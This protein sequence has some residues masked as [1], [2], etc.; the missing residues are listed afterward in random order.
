MFYFYSFSI[1][2]NISFTYIIISF[3]YIQ[4]LNIS[5]RYIKWEF[6][7][8]YVFFENSQ[9]IVI[10]T[11]SQ[12]TRLQSVSQTSW[13]KTSVLKDKRLR[14]HLPDHSRGGGEVPGCLQTSPLQGGAG[15][16][17][18]GHHLHRPCVTGCS[19]NQCHKVPWSW[20][21][22]LLWGFLWLWMWNC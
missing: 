17:Q 2:I 10:N 9:V 14:Q 3:I 19:G 8:Q 4:I 18:Q 1:Y 12:C 13:S 7:N 20:V 16:E 15:Q 5:V 11:L 21:L 22:Q 6:F